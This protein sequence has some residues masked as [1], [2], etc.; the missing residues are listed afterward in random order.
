MAKT[1]LSGHLARWSILFNE[2]EIVYIPRTAIKGQAL[3]NFLADHPIPTDW[4]IYEDFPDKEVFFVEAF[5][6]WMMFF[7]GAAWSDGAGAG[8]VF[9]SPQRQVLPY[10][11]ILGKKCSKNV[12]ECQT[13]IIDLQMAL[14]LGIT[15]L[16][17]SG[18]SKGQGA[19]RSVTTGDP[20]DDR[21]KIWGRRSVGA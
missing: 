1:V 15:S 6:P 19:G 12:V 7:H 9:V 17:I 4:K 10:A 5:Q 8:V 20:F 14:E 13:L 18:D 16:T 21:L 2:F 3:S 11:V